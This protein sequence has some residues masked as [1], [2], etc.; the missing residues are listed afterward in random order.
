MNV[1]HEEAKWCQT[2]LNS[3]TGEFSSVGNFDYFNSYCR[4]QYANACTRLARP[5]N[6]Q[7]DANV[8]VGPL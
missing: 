8:T 7:F 6:V 1:H 3:V 4:S 5:P 2:R